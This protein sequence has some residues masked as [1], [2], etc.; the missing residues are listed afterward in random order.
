VKDCD[1]TSVNAAEGEFGKQKLGFISMWLKLKARKT[2]QN[3]RDLH[4][5]SRHHVQIV[6]FTR[7]EE[8]TRRSLPFLSLGV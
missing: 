6:N 2:K 4:V 3:F 7:G 1:Q 5:K 8:T